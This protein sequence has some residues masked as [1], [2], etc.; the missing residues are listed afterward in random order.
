[1]PSKFSFFSV[2]LCLLFAV[3]FSA[4]R[5]SEEGYARWDADQNTMIDNNE[6]NTVWTET[7]YFGRWDANRDTYIEER[8]WNAGRNAYMPTYNETQ[9]GTFSDWDLD[10]DG[11]LSEEEFRD[12]TFEVY[13]VDRD[14]TLAEP[15]YTAWWG[16]FNR[17]TQATAE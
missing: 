7:G 3:Q 12:R 16:T 8:E 1:M 14:G 15:E 17:G 5:V 9:F 2:A 6:F 4:C 13:D 10:A 11:R